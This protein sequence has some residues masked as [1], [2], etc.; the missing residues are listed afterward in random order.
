MEL[1]SYSQNTNLKVLQHETI[2]FPSHSSKACK[3]VQ[4]LPV[5]SYQH[6]CFVAGCIAKVIKS[7]CKSRKLRAKQRE[8]NL[9]MHLIVCVYLYIIYNGRAGGRACACCWKNELAKK[10]NKNVIP[11]QTAQLKLL[12]L[13]WYDSSR[14]RNSRKQD[15]LYWSRKNEQKSLIISSCFARSK[16]EKVL[17]NIPFSTASKRTFC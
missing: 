1:E 8:N 5:L 9:I 2:F 11:I 13:C 15:F 7:K 4:K 3:L 12:A 16:R 17:P 6:V 14:E 10:A